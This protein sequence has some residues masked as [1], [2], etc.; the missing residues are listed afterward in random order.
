MYWIL[1]NP[2]DAFILLWIVIIKPVL[3]AS[4]GVLLCFVAVMKYKKVDTRKTIWGSIILVIITSLLVTG[5]RLYGYFHPSL[6]TK[7][8]HENYAA[9][10]YDVQKKQIVAA[11]KF[12]IT[13]FKDRKEADTYL[14]E[15]NLCHIRSNKNYQLARMDHSIPYLTKNASH[16]LNRIGENFRD[17]L[18][19]QNMSA[20][21]IYVTSILR[22][23]ADVE[24]LRKI[25]KIAVQNSAHRYA[26]TFDISFSQFVP[27]GLSTE[28]PNDLKRVLA[29]VL[30][31]LRDQKE[32]YVKYEETP[33]CFHIT[34]R[35]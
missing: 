34:C 10:F 8:G 12:G 21:K 15:G 28:T 18:A 14:Q 1:N 31:D 30:R 35:K 25:N 11:Q 9:H 24:R 13:P 6:N 29:E 27:I 20:Y 22:T 32:C 23:D 16:L 2:W 5:I 26:T 17:S 4:T 3:V 19:S 33:K 7:A